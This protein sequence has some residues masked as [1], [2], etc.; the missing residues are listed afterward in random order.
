MEK[1]LD[2]KLEKLSDK[3]MQDSGLEK[4]SFNF[5]DVV[6][7][8]VNQVSVNQVTA[9]KPLIPKAIWLLLAAVFI[10]TLYVI[11]STTETADA[12]WISVINLNMLFDNQLTNSFS[13]I[14]LSKTV[15]YSIV[16]FGIMFCVQIPI[17]K[18]HLDKRLEL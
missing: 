11:S 15:M 16:L 14:N 5:T 2:K 17:L 10:L 7:Q 4:P 13:S 12:N 1:H 6:M 3:V 8:Q 9:Y 18:N